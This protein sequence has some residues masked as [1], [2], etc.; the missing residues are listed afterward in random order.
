MMK[1]CAQ[2]GLECSVHTLPQVLT[3]RC[4]FYAQISLFTRLLD[5]DP[6]DLLQYYNRCWCY[7]LK[8]DLISAERDAR[9][10]IGLK[11]DWW[12]GH[13]R[14]GEVLAEKKLWGDAMTS[15]DK[16]RSL[17]PGAPIISKA[18][19]K[20]KLAQRSQGQ[21]PPPVLANAVLQTPAAATPVPAVPPVIADE[22]LKS[23]LD[24]A[25]RGKPDALAPGDPVTVV[26][27]ALRRHGQS[28][29]L[30]S[31]ISDPPSWK[32]QFS[33][34][35]SDSILPDDLKYDPVPQL[36]HAIGVAM[37]SGISESSLMTGAR[38]ELARL[39]KAT[40]ERPLRA[41]LEAAKRGINDRRLKPG[42]PITVI[43][44]H[45]S[46]RG[47]A[48]EVRQTDE[49]LNKC[50]ITFKD[51]NVS[52][53]M[54][55][56]DVT[57]DP[58][59]SLE[60]AIDAAATREDVGA[61]MLASAR[62]EV[63]L[64][65]RAAA[66]EELRRAIESAKS[67][68]SKG[69]LTIGD[70]VTIIG[71]A[72]HGQAEH[73]GE[74][75]RDFGGARPYMVRFPDGEESDYLASCDIQ[76]DELATLESSIRE[77]E[78]AAI[79]GGSLLAEARTQLLSL[80]KAAASNVLHAAIAGAEGETPLARLTLHDK[81]VVIRDATRRQGV[82][83]RDFD[84]HEARPYKVRFDDGEESDWLSPDN[85]ERD[86]FAAII[87]LEVAIAAAEAS[88]LIDE[89]LL[90][91]A[92][93]QVPIAKLAVAERPLRSALAVAERE[94][95]SGR[96]VIGD[97]VL[98]TSDSG[99]PGE[100]C[101]DDGEDSEEPYTVRFSDGEESEGLSA[102]DLERDSA[103]V[104]SGLEAA[105]TAAEAEAL[106][107][108]SLLEKARQQVP[109]VRQAVA[110]RPLR[111][112]LTKNEE[113]SH[114]LTVGDTVT[115][116]SGSRCGEACKIIQDDKDGRPYKVRFDDGE[117][118]DYLGADEIA[119]HPISSISSLEAA[120]T[121]AG[122][123]GLVDASLIDL[124]HSRLT[125]L[126]T[127]AVES[128]LR[129]ALTTA[130]HNSNDELHDLD[131]GDPVIIIK[132]DLEV[133]GQ[134]GEL[135][136]TGREEEEEEEDFEGH[137][138]RVRF[139]DGSLSDWLS[140]EDIVFNPLP[141]LE[142]ALEMAQSSE[143][144]AANGECSAPVVQRIKQLKARTLALVR[145][146]EAADA[147]EILSAFEHV[148]E[149][150]SVIGTEVDPDRKRLG[151][152]LAEDLS[153]NDDAA[154]LRI[155]I[156]RASQAMTFVAGKSASFA[157]VF[158]SAQGKVERLEAETRRR[159]ER[160][161]AGAQVELPEDRRPDRHKCP[162]TREVMVEPVITADGHTYER[163]QIER[164]LCDNSTS[165]TTGLHL[166]SKK[167]TDN[168]ALKQDINEWPERE[169]EHLMALAARDT[170]LAQPPPKRPRRAEAGQSCSVDSTA[171]GSQAQS[172]SA[173]SGDAEPMQSDDAQPTVAPALI[174]SASVAA[175]GLF[176]DV[177]A[178]ME[179]PQ[180]ESLYMKLADVSHVRVVSDRAALTVKLALRHVKDSANKK[181]ADSQQPMRAAVSE[182]LGWKKV[183]V[184]A[185]RDTCVTRGREVAGKA[186]DDLVNMLV[187]TA[188]GEP[189][190]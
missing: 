90:A 159:E 187:C 27:A 21:M 16:A 116:V 42:D 97:K 106:V 128:L 45:N 30:L 161:A 109:L 28:G 18:I 32:V 142:A 95:Q 20:A 127:H 52:D 101:V 87:G 62:A 153:R 13:L 168:I 158:P 137:T 119:W 43:G 129:Q 12:T 6:K 56:E 29:N 144:A 92:R 91:T 184:K 77:A 8:G 126:K 146:Q 104:I 57:F 171:L 64:L 19:E 44:S 132:E 149:A 17:E 162:I 136:D 139:S 108:E 156:D 178:R 157:R 54:Q 96:L 130:D 143:A 37:T 154:A 115:I 93:V 73:V 85:I 46:Q 79:V 167:L 74:I 84:Y 103:V 61:D 7:Q 55:I 125:A 122:E 133:R 80:K 135:C 1:R 188:F 105:I 69:R 180:L 179:Q 70:K 183:P 41:A 148:T 82:I 123:G 14:L 118:S 124:A 110:E 150:G 160:R 164:W 60:A 81:V 100:I 176:G 175:E 152:L 151:D 24:A 169:H 66:E 5:A 23:A 31:K 39:K 48:G 140:A 113:P 98:I 75:S 36:Q 181:F 9:T 58:L 174:T 112:A 72:A 34:S 38:D 172:A 89:S 53:W 59:P 67:G 170:D 134:A 3:W 65:K 177:F 155:A 120:I 22:K 173:S 94:T 185:L 163:A 71:G 49:R 40:A 186:K 11:H 189:A 33:P 83:I 111:A 86:P 47:Y 165:P 4:A 141:V 63:P 117:E 68:A 145:L 76:H 121:V 88:G 107:S 102:R 138:Y 25:R 99:Q 131:M 114:R 147:V 50:M 26:N 78:L 35:E 51:G 190:L 166:Q 15:L 10:M 182:L 2:A